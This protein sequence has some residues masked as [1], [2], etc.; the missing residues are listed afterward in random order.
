M[1]LEGRP[2]LHERHGGLCG[3]PRVSGR[4]TGVTPVSRLAAPE[5]THDYIIGKLEFTF[6]IQP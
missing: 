5:T 6:H 2:T 1:A 4:V 3:G